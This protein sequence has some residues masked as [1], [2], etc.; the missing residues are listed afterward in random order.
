MTPAWLPTATLTQPNRLSPCWGQRRRLGHSRAAGTGPLA[1]ADLNLE[2]WLVF[3]MLKIRGNCRDGIGFRVAGYG[4]QPGVNPQAVVV[5]DMVADANLNI[6]MER[7]SDPELAR[8][9]WMQPRIG[10]R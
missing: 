5:V 3:S 4:S 6:Y 8:Q 2:V 9:I 10:L 7:S 1:A